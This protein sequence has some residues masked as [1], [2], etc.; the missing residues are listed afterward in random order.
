MCVY[1]Y[2][3]V[4]KCMHVSVWYVCDVYVHVCVCMWHMCVYMYVYAYTNVC[5]CLYMVCV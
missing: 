2:A 1:I 5:M 3:C 4:Y